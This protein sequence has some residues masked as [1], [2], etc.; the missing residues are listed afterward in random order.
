MLPTAIC[1]CC[2][3]HAYYL[4]P[5]GIAMALLLSLVSVQV[6][7]HKEKLRLAQELQGYVLACVAS[8]HGNHVIQKCIEAVQPSESIAFV[9]EVAPCFL[10]AASPS[11]NDSIQSRPQSR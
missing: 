5:N 1:M 10:G 4:L 11:G 9:T 2:N 3:G 8:Q 7:E 6:L